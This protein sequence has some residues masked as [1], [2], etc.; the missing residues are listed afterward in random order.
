MNADAVSVE[1]L[2]QISELVAIQRQHLKVREAHMDMMRSAV[3]DLAEKREQLAQLRAQVAD[4]INRND[5]S[6]V[7]RLHERVT[8][9]Q[10][11]HESLTEKLNLTQDISDFD[12]NIAADS[13]SDIAD[14]DAEADAAALEQAENADFESSD[15][16]LNQF[17]EKSLA[18]LM[19]EVDSIDPSTE[20]SNGAS[21]IVQA[22][23]ST[24][25]AHILDI[26]SAIAAECENRDAQ[27]ALLEAKQSELDEFKRA[28]M[29]L[30]DDSPDQYSEER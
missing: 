19:A 20:S 16:R 10:Q 26:Q 8:E 6:E 3:A 21:E 28:I 27:I 29:E 4:A 14:Y 11:S 13:N 22:G 9:L 23:I 2:A 25:R 7:N 17:I 24:L 30:D 12:E 1:S 15:A 5:I 18:E